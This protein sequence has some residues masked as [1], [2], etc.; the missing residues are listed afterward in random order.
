MSVV[1]LNYG[2][3]GE[4]VA[5]RR[6]GRVGYTGQVAERETGWYLVGGRPYNPILRR[7]LVPDPESPMLDGGLNRYAYCGG[8]PVNRIDPSGNAWTDWLMA[9]LAVGLSVLGTIFSGGALLGTIAAAGS[10]TGALAAPGIAATAAAATLDVVSTVASIGSVASMATENQTA[11]SIFGWVGMA[12]GIGSAAATISAAKQGA[13]T[14]AR[15]T[16]KGGSA[17]R[18]AST[19]STSTPSSAPRASADAASEAGKGS[20]TLGTVASTV[21]VIRAAMPAVASNVSAR[22]QRRHSTGSLVTANANSSQPQLKRALN[23]MSANGAK[24]ATL[25]AAPSAS[26]QALQNPQARRE[27]GQRSLYRDDLAGAVQAGAATGVKV[28]TTDVA[29][30]TNEQI[31]R[32][33]SEDG[34]HVVVAGHGL[35]D[36]TTLRALNMTSMVADNL[37]PVRAGP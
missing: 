6:A 36:E 18:R 17:S 5:A 31:R 1:A 14:M 35:V 37:F 9:G 8:D 20:G 15:G 13:F 22:I 21:S 24:A 16:S 7:F 29:T 19:S 33:L 4:S 28:D 32:R 3:F 25:Y 2:A 30:L 10:L 23:D 12:T 26:R 11:N 34:I 27:S